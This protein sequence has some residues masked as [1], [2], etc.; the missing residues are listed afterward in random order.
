MV[1]TR[2]KMY[3]S[4]SKVYKWF[5]ENGFTDV[6]PFVHTRFSKDAYFQGLS[7]DGLASKGT[8][9]VLY[10]IKSNCKPSKK[11]Q[12]QMA[13]ASKNSGVIL[14][15]FDVVDRKGVCVYGDNK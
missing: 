9:L 1:N 6:F 13:L 11:I 5:S 15:W 10:Q 4:N 12:N 14:L 8:Q 7:F 2:Q 3:T